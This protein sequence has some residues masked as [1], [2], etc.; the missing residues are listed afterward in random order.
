MKRL[1]CP[2]CGH[3]FSWK[4]PEVAL[5]ALSR[6]CPSCGGHFTYGM[7]W[8]VFLLLFV[9]MVLLATYLR[10]WMG[11]WASMP[12][13]LVVIFFSIRL[14]KVAEEDIITPPEQVRAEKMAAEEVAAKSD[15]H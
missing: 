12:G 15:E 9:P 2:H 3:Q 4:A 1:Y 7:Q 10:E 6:V 13:V 8:T 5:F 11:T 14:V